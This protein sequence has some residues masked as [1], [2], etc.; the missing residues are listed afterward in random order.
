MVLCLI[1][2]YHA[3][4]LTELLLTWSILWWRWQLQYSQRRWLWHQFQRLS[5]DHTFS[6]YAFSSVEKRF[7]R[8]LATFL[9]L[10]DR[11]IRSRRHQCILLHLLNLVPLGT[12]ILFA[13]YHPAQYAHINRG[14]VSRKD[15]GDQWL[16]EDQRKNFP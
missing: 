5:H 15:F 8:S 4:I 7:R 1:D 11:Q 6:Y 10:L 16:Y 9:W 12:S 13:Y 2:T 14:W 3:S